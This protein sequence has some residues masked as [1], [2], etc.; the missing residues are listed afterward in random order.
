MIPSLCASDH[1][2]SGADQGPLWVTRVV[3]AVGKSK[4]WDSTAIVV[5]WDDWGG[6][7]DNAPPQRLN[8]TSL[9][10]RVP[11]IVISPYAKG[12][13]VSHTDYDFGSVL[14]FVEE[15]FNLGSLDTS[16][17]SANSIADAFDFSQRPRA[18]VPE[19]LP[20]VTP[21]PGGSDWKTVIKLDGGIP[22]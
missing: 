11:M 15:T 18:F 6:W 4:Y 7:Y 8:Y 2:A 3:N 12:G 10:F 21:C 22:E 13:Y 9:G 19:R 14:K 20:H 17:A 1:P 16:D 5:L